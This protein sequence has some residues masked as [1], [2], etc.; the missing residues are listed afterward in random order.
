MQE[1]NHINKFEQEY[2]RDN[3]FRV[4]DGYFDRFALRMSER[5]VE[6]QQSKKFYFK[7]LY[8]PIPALV[9]ASLVAGL[10]IFSIQFFNRSS[11]SLS[12]EEI[13][14]YVYQEGIDEFELDEIIEYS[15]LVNLDSS[16]TES[17]SNKKKETEVDEIQKFLLDED[18]EL[19]D[20][21]NEL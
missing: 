15:I 18:I 21:I 13:S 12:E 1:E 10:G 5:I 17:K 9:F 14:N 19:N 11:E 7:A 2:P 3:P 4:P 8:K 6:E 16:E 20:I